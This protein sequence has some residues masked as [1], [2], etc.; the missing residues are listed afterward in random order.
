MPLRIIRKDITE[1]KCDAIVNP[2]DRVLSHGGGLDARIHKKAGQDLSIACS[3]I[4]EIKT[5]EAKI[6]P[7]FNLKCK[8]VIHTAGP[9]WTGGLN[10]EKKLLQNCY[11]NCLKRAMEN[12]CKSIAIPLI[13][14]GRY[15]YP[16]D[17]VLKVAVSTINSF[18]QDNELNVYLVVYDD[19]SYEFSKKLYGQVAKFIDSHY[20]EYEVPHHVPIVLCIDYSKYEENIS[21]IEESIDKIEDSFAV[22]LLKLI[23]SKGMKDVDC[24]KKANVSRQTWYKILNAKNYKP[25]KNTAISFAIAL[26]LTFEETQNLLE[27]LGFTL[28]KS[29]K[30]DVI[31]E[32]FIKNGCDDIMKINETLFKFGEPCLAN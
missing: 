12:G 27:T 24:Y 22:T 19:K 9:I 30:F 13:S 3:L 7:A 5:G 4:G 10:G 11:I 17:K 26:K 32:Y 29:S 31:I 18:L 14:S 15:G 16:K 2:S 6:T 20:K 8:Y 23:D 21:L 28:S 1:M 25:S